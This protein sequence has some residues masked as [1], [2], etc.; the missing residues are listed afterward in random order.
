MRHKLLNRKLKSLSSYWNNTRMNVGRLNLHR[1]SFKCKVEKVSYTEI[2]FMLHNK[3]HKYD[4]IFLE[5]AMQSA[6]RMSEDCINSFK[7]WR[8]GD[9]NVGEIF[10]NGENQKK[11]EIKIKNFQKVRILKLEINS[12]EN[13]KKN[14]L[15]FRQFFDCFC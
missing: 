14:L 7:F 5:W 15:F 3:I 11:V 12:S 10:K 6:L 9:E 13:W 2:S 1:K 8:H 4:K